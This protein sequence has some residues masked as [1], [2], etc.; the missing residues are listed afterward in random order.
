MRS[1]MIAAMGSGSGKTIVTAGLLMALQ[2]RNI[3]V[4]S[5]KCGPDYIDPMFHTRVLGLPCRNLDFFLLGERGVLRE[6]SGI[7]GS[8][9]PQET[10]GGFDDF[11]FGVKGR[12]QESAVKEPDSSSGIGKAEQPL[13]VIEGA[14]GF[15][16]GIG[17]TTKA[18]A[19][20]I[21][22][23]LG[24]P[25]ILVVKP[26][27]Q[28][29]TLAAEICGLMNFRPENHIAGVILNECSAAL[30]D[31]LRSIIERE[32]GIP[33]FGYL[34]K[35]EEAKVESRHLGLLMADEIPEFRDRFEA[36]AARME[37]TVEIDRILACMDFAESVTDQE[38]VLGEEI[39]RIKM[40]GADVTSESLA[41]NVAVSVTDETEEQRLGAVILNANEIEF[42]DSESNISRRICRIAVARDEAFSFY[43][44]SSLDALRRAGA[45]LLPFSPLHDHCLPADVSGLYLGGGY[46]ENYVKE[47][48]ANR[49]MLRD[50]REAIEKG[51]PTVAECGGFMYLQ[52]K[53]EGSDGNVY[54]MVGALTGK[55]ARTPRL[56]RFGYVTLTAE[57]DSLLFRAGEP[58]PAHEFHHWD[59]TECGDALTARKYDG[60]NWKCG[61]VNDRLYAGYP[62]LEL[63]GD[64]PLAERFV[65]A[66]REYAAIECGL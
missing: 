44:A 8:D 50:I 57:A 28:S 15:Y 1:V 22:Q 24:T 35:M 40:Y 6:L 16:D 20:D 7:E 26:R 43:Y 13:A 32:C 52:E 61:V 5:F 62:H 19:Y 45:E 63:G 3:A 56:V 54:P 27:G 49:E 12:N 4:R 36:I 53:L 58:V 11:A 51:L 34:P 38:N 29:A 17:G 21:A 14:M 41:G 66:C 48:S 25:V 9:I 33:V 23:L 10:S 42:K 39:D 2:K 60:R 18:S 65:R 30:S 37:E 64:V 55:A 47:L 59:S 31:H 46:P